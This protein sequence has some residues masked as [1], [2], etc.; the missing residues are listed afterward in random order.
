MRYLICGDI[1]GNLPAL[2]NL[3]K[4]EKSN[5]DSFICHGDIVN[6]APWSNECVELI[7]TLPHAIKLL[8][9]HE[10][11]FVNGNYIGENLIA[12]AFFD[13]CYPKFDKIKIIKKY[14]DTYQLSNFTVQ[15][16]VNGQYVFPDTELSNLNLEKNYIIGHS[17]YQFDR[18]IKD[19]R[20]IN[21]GSLGQNREFINVANY[22]I[23]DD[24]SNY[25]QL[26]SFKFNIN[27]VID[28]MIEANYPEICLRYYKSKKT[29]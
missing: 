9:N 25:I 8:G 28:K 22:I 23:Y 7:E 12:R 19:K 14:L 10:V 1:H 13:F 21:T 27:I 16:T 18:K 20:L 2:E 11:N 26:K 15:H 3:L 6:Y 5:Y 24:D 4:I 17:H 29:L